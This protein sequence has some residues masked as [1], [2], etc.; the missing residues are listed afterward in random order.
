VLMPIFVGTLRPRLFFVRLGTGTGSTTRDLGP[1]LS[2]G[3][4][5]VEDVV[6]DDVSLGKESWVKLGGGIILSLWTVDISDTLRWDE[7]A[8]VSCS[9]EVAAQESSEGD[10]RFF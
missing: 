2:K 7:G 8:D 4:S 1:R 5:V 6:E 10:F 3:S 9:C